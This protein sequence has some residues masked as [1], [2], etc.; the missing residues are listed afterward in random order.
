M[1]GMWG[2]AWCGRINE[3]PFMAD[4]MCRLAAGLALTSATCFAEEKPQTITDKITVPESVVE[5]TLVKLPAGK[6]TIKDKDG[7][8]KEVEIKPVWIGKTEVT[9]D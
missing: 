3:K 8:D 4:E 2:S 7:K 1:A 9:W 5:F 6:I